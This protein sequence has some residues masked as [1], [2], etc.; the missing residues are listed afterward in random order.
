MDISTKLKDI[1]S[2]ESSNITLADIEEDYGTYPI[3]GANGLIKNIGTYKF[4][5][6]YIAIVKDGA[7]VGRTMICSK[8]SSILATMNSLIIKNNYP[9]NYIC[10]LIN[11]INFDKYI[12]G[13][14]IPHIYF[15]DYSNEEFKLHNIDIASKLDKIFKT[16]DHKIELSSIKLNKLIELKKGL[17]QNMFV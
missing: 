17:M 8:C 10:E 7:G 4:D 2:C 1:V 5:K 16:L 14:G 15:K 13:S 6:E 3:Y 12:V 11:T 9:L